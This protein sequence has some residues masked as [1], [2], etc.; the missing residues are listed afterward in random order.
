MYKINGNPLQTIITDGGFTSI[1][2]TLGC[3]GDSLASGEHESLIDGVSGYHDYYEY[4]WG[5]YIARRCGLKAYNWSVGGLTAKEFHEL[6]RCQTVFTPEKACQGYI[7]ALGVNDLTEVFK[8][9]IELGGMADV[10][11]ENPQ[12]NKDTV[13]G[14]YVH[15]IQRIKALQPKA[16]VF[17]TTMPFDDGRDE[18]H[19]KLYKEFCEIIRN[20]PNYFEYLYVI[21]FEKYAP[22]QNEEFKKTYYLGYHLNAMG[23]KLIADLYMTYID[24]II[25]N[26]PEDFAQV[27]FIGTNYYNE[28]HKW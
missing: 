2:R 1:F 10:D 27:G 22:T 20:L 18:A 28:K 24:H 25:R 23:Y 16:R 15:I 4:S 11:F 12:N 9:N 7:I 14:H 6:A 26:N 21:D 8:G 3:I 17:V 19:A 5:Q 13:V